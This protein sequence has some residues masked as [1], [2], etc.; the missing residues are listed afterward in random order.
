MEEQ[1]PRLAH[2]YG[3]IDKEYGLHL[4]TRQ[5][6]QDGPIFMVNLMKYHEVAQYTDD[7]ESDG[8]SGREADDKYNPSSI[9]SEEHTSELQ[10]H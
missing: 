9:R 6:D 5:P 2:N 3:R 1:K 8:I 10:S 4:A 7:S